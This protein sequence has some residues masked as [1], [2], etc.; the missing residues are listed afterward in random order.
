MC[1]CFRFRNGSEFDFCVRNEP[2]VAFDD[3]QVADFQLSDHLDLVIDRNTKVNRNFSNGSF[4]FSVGLDYVDESIVSVEHQGIF[5]DQWQRLPLAN[6][7]FHASEHASQ[8][9]RRLVFDPVL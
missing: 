9:Q 6:G 4:Q 2:F 1:L 7:D 5:R 3:N 8:K